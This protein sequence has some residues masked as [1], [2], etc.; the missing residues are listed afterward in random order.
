MIGAAEFWDKTA[1][2]YAKSPIAD[3]DSYEYT[4]DR[5]RSYLKKTDSVLEVGCGTGSTAL[6]LAGS[7]DQITASDLSGNMI[8]I[9]ERKAKEQ[10]ISNVKFLVS[11]I[12]GEALDTGPYDVVMAF[13]VIHLL[14]DTAAVMQRFHQLVRPG[15]Y[16]ISKTVC[17]P[18]KGTSL[19]LRAMLTVLPMLQWIGKAPFVNMIE[20]SELEDHVT[21]AG[22]KILETGN[23]PISPPSRY[24]VAQRPE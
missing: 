19:K 18:G 5:T 7:V 24:I 1:E 12:H 6:L 21:G 2:R 17:R 14:A 23:H 4:L 13:N 15:G 11:D 22:F 3:M 20:I 10:G 16:F 8:A 9:G